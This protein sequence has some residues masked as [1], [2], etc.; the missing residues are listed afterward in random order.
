MLVVTRRLQKCEAKLTARLW[1]CHYERSEESA[2]ASAETTAEETADPSRPSLYPNKRKS[3]ARWG[4]GSAVR[5]DNSKSPDT[6]HAAVNGHERNCSLFVRRLELGPGIA[7]H[8]V[9]DGAL[10]VKFRVL[11]QKRV[12]DEVLPARITGARLQAHVL[13]HGAVSRLGGY[14]AAGGIRRPLPLG[15]AA[16]RVGRMATQSALIACFL[17]FI[18]VPVV[19]EKLLGHLDVDLPFALRHQLLPALVTG[20]H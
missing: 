12:S 19:G 20:I 8:V 13:R 17:A 5:D 18:A 11:F 10:P 15:H 14:C 4:P 6:A 1:N 9:Q 3:G 2:F 7:L 16:R